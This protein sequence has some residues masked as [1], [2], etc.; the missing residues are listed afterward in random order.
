M[1]DYMAEFGSNCTL[2][3]EYHAYLSNA[4]RNAWREFIVGHPA[5]IA[6][7]DAKIEVYFQRTI[8]TG[9]P[10]ADK[11]AFVAAELAYWDAAEALYGVAK[12]WDEERLA[13]LPDEKE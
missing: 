2:C 11:A 7:R 1:K 6:E 5:Q 10:N 13:K 3:G 12:A 4:E 8:A 9:N